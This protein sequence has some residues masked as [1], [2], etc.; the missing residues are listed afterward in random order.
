MRIAII[1]TLLV[2]LTGCMRI[3]PPVNE[4][5][6][7]N[8]QSG[9]NIRFSVPPTDGKVTLFLGT[10]SELPD[11]WSAHLTIKTP[12]GTSNIPVRK[13]NLLVAN[14]LEKHGLRAYIIDNARLPPFSANL[15]EVEIT[16]DSLHAPEDLSLWI[17]YLMQ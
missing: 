5:V 12:A 1:L 10:K 7:S 11:D 9:R 8:L 2:A 13:E 3:R 14:W 4:M 6:A 17:S 16:Y 15:T